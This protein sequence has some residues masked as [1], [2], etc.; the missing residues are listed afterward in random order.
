MGLDNKAIA[1][2]I[3]NYETLGSTNTEALA[4]ARAG[5]A[6]PVWVTAA[7]QTAGRGRRGRN[8][9]SEPGNLYASLLLTDLAQAE[10]APELSFVASL[11][12]HDAVVAL[13]PQLGSRLSLKWPND[14]LL[15]GAKLAGILLE[16][17]RMPG[18]PLAVV[19]GIGVN[20]AHHPDTTGYPATDLAAQGL[21]VTPELLLARLAVAFAAWLGEWEAGFAPIRAAWLAHAM[22][23][24]SEIRVQLPERELTG[25]FESL[26]PNGRLLLRLPSGETELVLAGDVFGLAPALGGAA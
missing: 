7:R 8:W 12:L 10:R 6:G 15:D 9:V 17:E 18:R 25:R 1:T 5:E 14:V 22:G 24:G 20:C 16:A 21:T 11:A 2:R 23:L 4:L 3:R 13:A 26:D 19:I